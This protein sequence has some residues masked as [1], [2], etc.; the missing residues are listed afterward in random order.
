MQ[1]HKILQKII[2]ITFQLFKNNRIKQKQFC[3]SKK[4]ASITKR[5]QRERKDYKIRNCF[6]NRRSVQRNVQKVQTTQPITT[7]DNASD[8]VFTTGDY[9]SNINN[10]LTFLLHFAPSDRLNNKE[11][12]IFKNLNL[13]KEI[14]FVEKNFPSEKR[15]FL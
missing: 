15:R 5:H 9:Q 6:H 1:I 8:F 2:L 10:K 14:E 4:N 13:N 7:E 11:R 3:K 12:F